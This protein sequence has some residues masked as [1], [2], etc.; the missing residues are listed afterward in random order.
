MLQPDSV[1]PDQIRQYARDYADACAEFNRRMTQCIQHLR[2]GNTA[3][4][5]RLSEMKPNL[6]EMITSLDFAERDAWIDIVSTLGFGVPPFLQVEQSKELNDAYFK[7]SPL[8]PLLRWHRLYALNGSPI[9]ERLSVIRA[10]AK[11]DPENLFWQE[12]QEKFEK[13]RIKQLENDVQNAIESQ[14]KAKISNL[15]AELSSSDWIIPPPSLLRQKLCAAVLQNYADSLMKYYAISSYPDAVGIYKSMQSILSNNSM[16][17]PLLIQHTIRPAITWLSETQKRNEYQGVFNRCA[18][19]LEKAIEAESL[20]PV[21]KHLYDALTNVARQSEIEIPADLEE[22]YRSTI[23]SHEQRQKFIV[24]I[25]AATILCVC[26]FFG[27]LFAWGWSLQNYEKRIQETLANLQKIEDEKLLDEIPNAIQQIESKKSLLKEEQIALAVKRLQQLHEVDKK[28]ADDFDRYQKQ[29][30]NDLNSQEKF[31]KIKL[32]EIQ[33]TIKQ[34]ENIAR[35]QKEKNRITELQ[36][37]FTKIHQTLLQEFDSKYH[38]EIRQAK[39]K[40]NSLRKND[41]ISANEKRIQLEEVIAKIRILQQHDDISQQMKDELKI[42]LA[43]INQYKLKVDKEAEQNDAFQK[44]L[45]SINW[46]SYKSTL[47]AF[48]SRHADHQAASDAGEVAAEFDAVKGVVADLNELAET[49]AEY[50]DDIDKLKSRVPDML[51]ILKNLLSKISGSS[52]QLADKEAELKKLSEIKPHTHNNFKTTEQ[53]LKI[54]LQREVFPYVDSDQRW[55]YLTKKPEKSGESYAYITSFRSDQKNVL[56]TEDDLNKSRE[57]SVNQYQFSVEALKKLDN[58]NNNAAEVV[59]DLMQEITN[60]NGLDPILKCALLDSFI[61]DMSASDPI[62][63]AQFKRCHEIVTS[64]DVDV[65]NTNWMDVSS[66]NTIPQRNLAATALRRI[67][68]IKSLAEKVKKEHSSFRDSLKNTP[69]NLKWIGILVNKEGEWSC[70][71]KSQ[72]IPEA[73]DVYILRS[74][75]AV[76]TVLPIKIGNIAQSTIQI[77][78]NQTSYIQCLPIFVKQ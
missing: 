33:T 14:N 41:T 64:S 65:V 47:E 29:I 52:L 63:A 73:G 3:E 51:K 24:R 20:V 44:M 35:T 16:S 54:L 22:L 1:P 2:S 56:V 25:I 42:F 57:L 32:E 71:T 18:A 37:K 9:S 58:I 8:E 40:F 10:I 4:C 69:P 72:Q 55:Y 23:L 60:T 12:D 26:V 61:T 38:A 45:A 53:L 50:L 70:L 17:M 66:R 46:A 30:E 7:I 15:Y 76:N 78:T 75:P 19:E 39:D 68:D 59:C 67:P 27:S 13:A 36:E 74:Q 31:D 43:A 11:A 6:P 62:F 28:R 21:L 77:N 48:V 5:I 34:A 49:Y